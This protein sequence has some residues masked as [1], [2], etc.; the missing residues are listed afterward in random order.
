MQFYSYYMQNT[1]SNGRITIT[2]KRKNARN[3]SHIRQRKDWITFIVR[4]AVKPRLDLQ[5]RS[6]ITILSAL[7]IDNTR[8]E[9]RGACP[10]RKQHYATPMTLS[11]Y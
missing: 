8:E 3:R 6:G 7:Q 11:G 9:Q 2:L 10:Q 5:I 4:M 1:R